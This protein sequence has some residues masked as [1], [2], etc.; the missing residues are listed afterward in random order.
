MTIKV[1]PQLCAGCGDCV[2]VCPNGAIYMVDQRAVIDETLCTLCEACLDVC[3][4]GAISAQP[5]P[6]KSGALVTLPSQDVRINPRPEAVR[7]PATVTPA[8]KLGLLAGAALTF[9]GREI[10]P[11]IADSLMTALDRRLTRPTAP[12]SAWLESSP[13][14][15][16]RRRGLQKQAR[17]RRGRMM[18]RNHTERR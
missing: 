5:E 15:S 10:A 7:Q 4:N 8:R 6:L 18:S 9:L 13:R 11:R 2:E 12:E 1:D 3:V 16:S 14:Q 17:Y